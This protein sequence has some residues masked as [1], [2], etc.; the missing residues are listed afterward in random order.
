MQVVVSIVAATAL[1]KPSSQLYQSINVG[2]LQQSSTGM[3]AKYLGVSNVVC[4]TAFTGQF[5]EPRTIA[6]TGID[7]ELR[8]PMGG[9]SHCSPMPVG[10]RCLDAA[11]TRVA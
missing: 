5:T 9:V 4:N 10:L 7:V 2:W 3:I 6:M 1:R 11:P 8:D